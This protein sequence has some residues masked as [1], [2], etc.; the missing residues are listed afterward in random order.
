MVFSIITQVIF[1][2]SRDIYFFPL[3][4]TNI[5]VHMF[6]NTFSQ[7]AASPSSKEKICSRGRGHVRLSIVWGRPITH[8]KVQLTMP[9]EKCG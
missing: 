8:Q 9:T 1:Q 6:R 3:A 5:L 4:S 7:N 2:G